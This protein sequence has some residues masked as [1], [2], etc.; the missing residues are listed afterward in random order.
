MLLN[1]DQLSHFLIYYYQ[2]LMFNRVD[3]AL[4]KIALLISFDQEL[5]EL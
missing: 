3:F 5:L 4:F 2:N 1:F